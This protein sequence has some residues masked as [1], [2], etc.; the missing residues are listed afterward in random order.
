M[1]VVI[2]GAGIGGLTTALALQQKGIDVDVY[3]RSAVLTDVGAGISLWPNALK[4]L[5][6][7][8]LRPALDAVSF[9]S[10]EGRFAVRTAPSCPGRH[11]NSSSCGWAC[12]SWSFIAPSC[13]RCSSMQRAASRSISATSART[14][15]R[16]PVA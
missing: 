6:Q 9:V 1:R 12:R 2:I 5:Y 16:T 10:V 7:L 14:S 13:W 8:G 4:A 11:P 3:E 15:R